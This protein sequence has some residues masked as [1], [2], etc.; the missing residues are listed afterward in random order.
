MTS[1]PGPNNSADRASAWER[2][3]PDELRRAAGEWEA[4]GF[5]DYAAALR[6]W[7]N[8]DRDLSPA[9]LRPW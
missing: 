4:L 9:A 7:A 8:G 2:E 5:S 1:L 3:D 6:R